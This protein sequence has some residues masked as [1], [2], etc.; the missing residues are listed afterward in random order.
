MRCWGG[1][2]PLIEQVQS[3]VASLNDRVAELEKPTPSVVWSGSSKTATATFVLSECA[4]VAVVVSNGTTLEMPP[5]PGTYYLPNFPDRVS[6]SAD[7]GNRYTF[8]L[9]VFS[10]NYNISQIIAYIKP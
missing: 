7:G 9:K 8:T 1:V 10:G 6:W 3:A 4:K 2:L 5:T